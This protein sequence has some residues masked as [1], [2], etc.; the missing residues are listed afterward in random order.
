MTPLPG[1]SPPYP[2]LKLAVFGLLACNAIVYAFGNALSS[3]VDTVAWLILLVLFE[4]ETECRGRW[5]DGSAPSLI[6]AARIAAI[7]GLVASE[8]AFAFGGAWIDVTNS[9]LWIGVVALLEFEVRFPLVVMCQPGAYLAAA[10]SLYT[11]LAVL[12]VVWA[13]RG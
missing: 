4:L 2:K 5:K 7:L 10:I 13:W 9:V 6:H 12:V 1:A 3:T 8:I 11:G